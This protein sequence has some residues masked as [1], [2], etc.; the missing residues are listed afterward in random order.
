MPAAEPTPT[1]LDTL[2]DALSRLRGR[3]PGPFGPPGSAGPPPGVH[4]FGP[5]H[6]ER[7]HGP[8]G[9]AARVRMLDALAT[10]SAPLTV[11]DL[12]ERIGV[13]QPRASKLV[14]QGSAHGLVRREADPDDAR[15]TRIALTDKGLA[16]A[17]GMRGERR[18]QLTQAL[19]GFTTAERVDLLRLLVKLADS[20]PG[21]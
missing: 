8:R 5:G 11:S 1:E 13:D 19:A 16:V 18:D 20:W 6:G 3:G 12:G 14:Q 4:R 2:L 21:R 9:G 7:G 15:R 17:R 10:A